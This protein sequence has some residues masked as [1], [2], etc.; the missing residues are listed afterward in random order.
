MYIYTHI[1]IQVEE[2]MVERAMKKLFLDAMVV[3]QGR[4]SEKTSA[5]DKE[6]LLEMIRFGAGIITKET[7]IHV[8]Y[9]SLS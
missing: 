8:C 7:Y 6:Q 9:R 1:Y 2:R 4:L 3:Q 5:A